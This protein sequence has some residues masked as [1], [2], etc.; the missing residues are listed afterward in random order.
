[1]RCL[2]GLSAS[3]NSQKIPGL[4]FMGKQTLDSSPLNCL[5]PFSMASP[6]SLI[7]FAAFFFLCKL[8]N[9]LYD[10]GLEEPLPPLQTQFPSM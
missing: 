6:I 8:I 2:E 1:M 3:E 10:L 5:N 4:Y 9:L 7:A